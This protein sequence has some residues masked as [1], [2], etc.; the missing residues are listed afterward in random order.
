MEDMES[1]R[2]RLFSLPTDQKN[3]GL[4][5]SRRGVQDTASPIYAVLVFHHHLN[6]YPPSPEPTRTLGLAGPSHRHLHGSIVTILR[7][8]TSGLQV[9]KDGV[10]WIPV[11]PKNDALIVN[12]GDFTRILSNGRFISVL[13]RVVVKPVGVVACQ[14]SLFRVCLI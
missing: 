13:H 1:E 8:K 12:L 3:E 9:F 14:L 10:G 2:E 11:E 7:A 5:I 6:S 4:K